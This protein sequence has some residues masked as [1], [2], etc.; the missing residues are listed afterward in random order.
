MGQYASILEDLKKEQAAFLS[1]ADRRQREQIEWDSLKWLTH[2]RS[3][4]K[5]RQERP[6]DFHDYGKNGKP[7]ETKSI[8][9]YRIAEAILKYIKEETGV[10]FALE[11][12]PERPGTLPNVIYF[13]NGR[14]WMKVEEKAVG[15]WLNLL[16]DAAQKVGLSEEDSIVS[17][18][19][20]GVLKELRELI[21]TLGRSEKTSGWLNLWNGTLR[22]DLETAAVQFVPHDALHYLTHILPYAYKP[23][24]TAPRFEQFLCRILPKENNRAALMEFLGSCFLPGRGSGKIMLAFGTQNGDN[25]KSTLIRILE[26]VLGKANVSNY[27][28]TELSNKETVRYNIVGKLLN[29]GD[30]LGKTLDAENIKKM[31]S[32]EPVIIRRMYGQPSES[33]GYARLVGNVNELPE[34][35]E[36]TESFFKRLFIVPFLEVIPK[37]EQDP[38]LAVKICKEERCGILLQILE[39]ARRLIQNNYQID[40][41]QTAEARQT[42]RA[43]LN[44]VVAWV[45]AVSPEEIFT[46]EELDEWGHPTGESRSITTIEAGELYRKFIRWAESNDPSAAKMSQTKFGRLAQMLPFRKQRSYQF[47]NRTVYIR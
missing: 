42:Y 36:I 39:G 43:E 46:E 30:E 15:E 16:S 44:P 20:D 32:G 24:A 22:I 35:S 26:Q 19:R 37:E 3:I 13:W 6:T 47:G 12:R 41:T 11:M 38:G 28:L 23:D 7:T 14:L 18:F 17:T 1:E 5:N 8:Y 34:A 40:T 31:A 4:L 10:R 33:D 45:E 9:Y 21:P 29:W 27:S 25:G 2:F